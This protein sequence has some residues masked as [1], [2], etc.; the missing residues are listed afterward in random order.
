M[1]VSNEIIKILDNL[2]KRFGVAF[3]WSSSNIAPYLEDL[4]GRFI[5]YEIT[6]HGIWMIIALIVA[7]VGCMVLH[8]NKYWGVY[9]YSDG[10]VDNNFRTLMYVLIILLP[11]LIFVWNLF[12][13]IPCVFLPEKVIIEELNAMYKNL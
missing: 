9:H 7:V 8:K 4:C 12:E 6:I 3:D 10:E 5:K 1:S 11:S 2:G 13:I